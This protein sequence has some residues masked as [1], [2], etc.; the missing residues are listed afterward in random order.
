VG[1]L[2]I[3]YLAILV[4]TSVV[5]NADVVNIALHK[6]Y[7]MQ[8]RP[9]YDDPRPDFS[10]ANDLIKL[11]DGK[12]EKTWNVEDQNRVRWIQDREIVSIDARLARYITDSHM[13]G[14]YN[15]RA[16]I[17]IDLG[18]EQ[19]FE[20]IHVHAIGGDI[21]GILLPSEIE[22]WAGNDGKHF[23]K[24]DSKTSKD[25]VQNGTR[26]SYVFSSDN[27][28][29]SARFVKLVLRAAM[30]ASLQ[31]Y[32][33]ISEIEILHNSSIQ[34]QVSNRDWNESKEDLKKTAQLNLGRGELLAVYERKNFETVLPSWDKWKLDQV[35][36]CSIV[37]CNEDII[38]GWASLSFT[39]EREVYS[40]VT[41]DSV[42]I[43]ETHR[44]G[45]RK[46]TA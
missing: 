19:K 31:K 4:I 1:F 24:L 38:V 9:S 2:P 26:I 7:T 30:A 42:Y 34:E 29:T 33:F 27:L 15:D 3:L 28:N 10:D 22:Y 35:P 8:P 12:F 44:D 39:S 45:N 5:C 41:E 16:I 46:C 36:G 43:T 32:I 13:V 6:S 21:A 25:L 14:W 37:A 17:T 40:D 18:Q 20:S 23:L 11:T